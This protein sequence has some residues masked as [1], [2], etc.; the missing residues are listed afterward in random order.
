M[1]K[2]VLIRGPHNGLRLWPSAN[3]ADN[4]N[5][6]LRTGCR[7]YSMPNY[8]QASR[9]AET[10]SCL[11]PMLYE[12]W[13]HKHI[14]YQGYYARTESSVDGGGDWKYSISNYY[15]IRTPMTQKLRDSMLRRGILLF[16]VSSLR[17]KG[18]SAGHHQPY[19]DSVGDQT[20]RME[21]VARTLVLYSTL[22]VAR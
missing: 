11:T 13:D 20:P 17:L 6:Q 1:H 21:V 15:H 7:C 8:S 3:R 10:F 4:S 12:L 14:R 9:T 5:N 18:G 22:N 19:S 16:F 2:C